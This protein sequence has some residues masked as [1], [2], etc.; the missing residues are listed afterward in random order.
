VEDV[1]VLDLLA[2]ASYAVTFACA[3][4][5]PESLQNY[6]PSP[7]LTNTLLEELNV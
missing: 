1:A 6:Y 4:E 3:G 5:S 2:T 7:I